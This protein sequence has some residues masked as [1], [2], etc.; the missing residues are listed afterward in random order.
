MPTG[1]LPGDLTLRPVRR[2]A[3]DAPEGVPLT[4]AVAA[5]KR[6]DPAITNP[7]VLAEHLRALPRAFRLLAAIDGDG[8]VRA[9]AGFG[10]FGTTA[11]VI[12]VNTDPAWRRRG[13]GQAMTATALRTAMRFGARQA[14]LDASDTGQSIYGRLGFD[15]ATSLTRFRRIG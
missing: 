11:S 13:I 14:G 3:G 4:H 15:V 6:A 7:D 12:F 8:I 2:L 5:A 1:R 10:T 9:T